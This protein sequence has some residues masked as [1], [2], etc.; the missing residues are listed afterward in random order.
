MTSID[1]A[2]MYGNLTRVAMAKM[3]A[4]YVLDLGLQELD[5][6]KECNF[7]DVSASLDEAYDNGVTKACQLGLM[8]VG[9]EKFNPNGIVTRAEFGTV[10]SRALWGDEY[11]DATPYYKA[12][13]EALKA[14]G[15][16]TKIDNPEMKEVR[17]YVMI[18]MQRADEDYTPAVGC[19]AEELLAC[20]VADDPDACIAAC[21]DEEVEPVEVKSGDL[22]VTVAKNDGAIAFIDRTSELDYLTFKGSERITL[23]KVSLERYG[24]SNY[25][26]VDS[27]WLENENGEVVT[28]PKV[29]NNK[30]RV[31]LI[32]KRDFRDV[33]DTTYAVVV[34]LKNTANPAGTIGFK[35]VDVESS[36]K[37]L[38]LP[39]GNANLY[40]MVKY[41]GTE[42]TIL[43]KGTTRS[44]YYNGNEH[45]EVA[46]LQV[47]AS[48]AAVEV[49][50][51]T[52]TNNTANKLDFGRYLDDVVV[53]RDNVAMKNVTFSVK[54]DELRINFTKDTI[55]ARK[56]ALYTV[57]IKLAGLD[58]F[59]DK[60]KFELRSEG[61]FSAVEAK[62]NA[63]VSFTHGF[64]LP[65]EEYTF[66]GDKITLTNGKLAGTVYGAAGST[67]VVVAEGTVKLNE[68]IKLNSFTISVVNSATTNTGVENI[69]IVIGTD[70]YDGTPN[71]NNSTRTSFTFD[72]VYIEKSSDVKIMVDLYDDAT[73]TYTFNPNSLQLG[74]IDGIYEEYNQSIGASNFVGSMKLSALR[75]E[76]ARGTLDN[77]VSKDLEVKV[78]DATRVVIFDGDYSARRDTVELNQ[79]KI[80]G[81]SWTTPDYVNFYLYVDGEEV[82]YTDMIGV[83]EYFD[84][85]EIKDGKTVKVKLEAEFYVS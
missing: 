59:T 9:I 39:K 25:S 74:L 82:A 84:N 66:N 55:E 83:E 4:N 17:G 48:N 64:P 72:N 53:L 62:T 61:D 3:V 30:D 73:G 77:K 60:V 47:K 50:G 63:R 20:I 24:F 21:S 22:A 13:L 16:M 37:N 12:H 19:S 11:N 8:G 70:E 46:R 51:F 27:I 15:I 1:N 38:V 49:N 28:N 45:Y 76:A 68:P 7:P 35:V 40:S 26:D 58:R 32:V 41:D 56:N 6:D 79:F 10:L 2:D 14:E 67:D 31:D 81:T 18:M 85:I 34:K 23:N 57:K 36:A 5:T 33:K 69:K 80:T 54:N 78:Q 43:K 71:V 75:A 29:V 65:F 44:Y 52:L 42:V